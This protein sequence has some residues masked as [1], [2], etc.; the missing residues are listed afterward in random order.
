MSA[1]SL[2]ISKQRARVERFRCHELG[3]RMML[4]IHPNARTVEQLAAM[5][6]KLELMQLIL[7]HITAT[8]ENA[9]L[10]ETMVELRERVRCARPML[11]VVEA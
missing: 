2:R 5:Q 1:Q 6:D 7:D 11:R 10:R 3:L 4:N 8:L 9:C